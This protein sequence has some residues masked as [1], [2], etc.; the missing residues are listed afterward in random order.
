MRHISEFGGAS[1]AHVLGKKKE[2]RRRSGFFARPKECALGFNSFIAI[3]WKKSLRKMEMPIKLIFFLLTSSVYGKTLK[4]SD[5]RF[6]YACAPIY[7]SASLC[8]DACSVYRPVASISYCSQCHNG[9]WAIN[10]CS[11]G[12]SWRSLP[13]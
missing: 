9:K 7:A 11:S 4:L 1:C 10:Y 6:Y 8:V 12:F 5:K 3:I 13:E 2:R